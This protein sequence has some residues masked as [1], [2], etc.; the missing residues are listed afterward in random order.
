M[1]VTRLGEGPLSSITTGRFASKEHGY[2]CFFIQIALITGIFNFRF[3]CFSDKKLVSTAKPSKIVHYCC[4]V[5]AKSYF[6]H[7]ARR[8]EHA[9]KYKTF[10]ESR[11]GGDAFIH[12]ASPLAITN[13]KWVGHNVT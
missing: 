3:H 8:T 2:D 11:D 4:K 13:P 6:H 1:A 5:I 10:H 12:P 7:A 9:N